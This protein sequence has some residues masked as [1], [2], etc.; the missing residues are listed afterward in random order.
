MDHEN[1]LDRE[2]VQN[3]SV[4]N[5][6]V[7]DDHNIQIG[8]DLY[9]QSCAIKV[10]SSIENLSDEE[11][12][13][14]SI[15][16][17]EN[18]NGIGEE[19]NKDDYNEVVIENNPEIT[20]ED[21]ILDYKKDSTEDNSTIEIEQND[22]VNNVETEKKYEKYLEDLYYDEKETK[23]DSYK[24]SLKDQLKG[25]EQKH[26]S[27][28]T[29]LEK[30]PNILKTDNKNS[31]KN[32][33]IAYRV[34]NG[35]KHDKINKPTNKIDEEEKR[36]LNIK[37]T[38][39]NKTIDS[40]KSSETNEKTSDLNEKTLLNDEIPLHSRSVFNKK[41]SQ[42][43][44]KLKS[45]KNFDNSYKEPKIYEELSASKNEDSLFIKVIVLIILIAL[46]VFILYYMFF[47]GDNTF[48]V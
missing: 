31:K 37:S 12:G 18:N 33:K 48:R 28:T 21:S 3:C 30:D 38:L 45:Q 34:N 24:L 2:S 15:H 42:Y 6:P 16:K 14:V 17:T 35:E 47:L 1:H 23:K 7:H 8:N 26:G 32:D 29:N 13:D 5:K 9:C 36:G 11:V 44:N 25:Y 10:L 40:L 27:I 39:S 43:K 46:I 22:D 41:N 19:S 20:V 4:C